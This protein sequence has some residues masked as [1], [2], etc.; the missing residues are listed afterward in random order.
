MHV[1]IS[2]N[3]L[4]QASDVALTSLERSPAIYAGLGMPCRQRHRADGVGVGIVKENLAA[5]AGV[6]LLK[7]RSSEV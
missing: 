1:Q 5:R 2:R 4:R 3:E 7:G 6:Q